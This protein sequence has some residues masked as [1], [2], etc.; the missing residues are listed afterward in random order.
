MLASPLLCSG[1]I[2]SFLALVFTAFEDGFGQ[3]TLNTYGCGTAPPRLL[4]SHLVPPLAS[5]HVAMVCTSAISCGVVHC[6]GSERVRLS[7]PP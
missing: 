7:P 2:L 3:L 5:I 1:A 6:H 4:R